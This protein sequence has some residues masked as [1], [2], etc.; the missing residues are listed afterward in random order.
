MRT[1]VRIGLVLMAGAALA[2]CGTTTPRYAGQ[3]KPDPNARSYTNADGQRIGKPYQV[4]GVWY[5]PREQPNY[6]EIGIASWYGPGFHMKA[7]ATGETFDMDAVSAA[8][9]TLPLPSMVEVTNLANGR[10][11]VVKVNDRGP[12]VGDRIIDLSRE[13]ARQLGYEREGVTR[14]RV[15]YLGPPDLL[16]RNDG[17]RYAKN[18]LKDEVKKTAKSEAKDSLRPSFKFSFKPSF[19]ITPPPSAAPALLAAAPA[20]V[21]AAATALPKAVDVL[22]PSL[23]SFPSSQGSPAVS[24][25]A[26]I[27]VASLP[28]PPPPPPEA[29]R[30]SGPRTMPVERDAAIADVSPPPPSV[31]SPPPVPVSIKQTVSLPTP[32][33][34]PAPV[35]EAPPVEIASS[36]AAPSVSPPSVD[37]SVPTP[38]LRVQAGAFASRANAQRAVSQLA[39]AG[40]ATIEPM[41]RADGVTLY[42]VVLAAPADEAAAYALRDK[43]EEIGFADAQVVRLF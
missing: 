21:A 36:I 15:R 26:P 18:E 5:V 1:A 3:P 24:R 20:A 39:A 7:T 16:D 12:F 34:E 29:V 6:D 42:R 23:P 27:S 9:T 28:P 31:A 19:P 8:H 32:A 13:A 17:L 41:T 37:V 22:T 14:V 33:A 43:V 2:A 30:P 38:G 11:L 40:P 4:G 35:A 10:K 25:P